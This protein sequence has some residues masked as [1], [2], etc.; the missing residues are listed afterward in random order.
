MFDIKHLSFSRPHH[1][2]FGIIFPIIVT[3]NAAWQK[4]QSPP[5]P[6]PLSPPPLSLPL[7]LLLLL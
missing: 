1:L 2:W 7:L 3:Y 5:P 4:R 6:P